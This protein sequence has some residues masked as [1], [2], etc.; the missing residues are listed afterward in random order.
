[1]SDMRRNFPPL[2]RFAVGLLLIGATVLVVRRQ[3]QAPATGSDWTPTL[4]SLSSPAGGNSSAPQ[5]TR[6]GGRT[7]LSWL[8]A[9]DTGTS[10][11]FAERTASGWSEPR[12]AAA[13]DNLVVNFA[14]TPAV[15]LTA[16]GTLVAHWL[17]EDGPDPEA[18][19][20]HLSWSRDEGR[21]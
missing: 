8:E 5:L 2:A 12:T 18:Y 20:L 11:K 10:L 9:S 21:T 6:S 4:E 14:D 3:S 7:I 17:E 1:M 16:G 15:R 19:T 13:G